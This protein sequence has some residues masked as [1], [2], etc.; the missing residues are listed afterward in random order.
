MSILQKSATSTGDIQMESHYDPLQVEHL[1]KAE[2]AKME[3]RLRGE[4]QELRQ[5][6]QGL[7]GIVNKLTYAEKQ[8]L[9][10]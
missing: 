5:Q 1:V 9:T 10:D 3:E 2:V 7:R 4:M 8:W 6:L